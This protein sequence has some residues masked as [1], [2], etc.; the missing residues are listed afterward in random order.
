MKKVLTFFLTVLLCVTFLNPTVAY[1]ATIK[2]NK[3][4][5][6]LD[7]GKSYTLKLTGT[8]KTVKW[9]TSNKAVATV[10]SKGVVKAVKA[11]TA[12]IT[13][14]VSSKKYTCKVTVKE[15]FNAQKAV[16]NLSAT[17]YDTNR[18]VLQIVKNNYS[19]PMELHATIVY[20]DADNQMIDKSSAANYHF[21]KGKECVLFFYA[22]IDS[23]YNY[24]AYDHYKITYSASAISFTKSN[25][26]DIKIESN[27]GADNV[28]VEV[29]ND[30]DSTCEYT[31]IYIIFYK[32]GEVVGYDYRYANVN[33]PG[34]ID[35]LDF[36]F[37]YD[38]SYDTIDIDDYSVYVNYSYSYDFD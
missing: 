34:S 10:S 37:P 5:L 23:D 25:L 32:D 36:S 19:F 11:G 38:E 33:D 17:T 21:E 22:P 2:L 35:Y 20:Y 9:S 26:K 28:M 24:V 31:Q 13:A 3:T 4:K 1:S 6:T 16:K 7:E 18:G 15:V 12:T 27:I 14:K 29:T 8:T 30:G